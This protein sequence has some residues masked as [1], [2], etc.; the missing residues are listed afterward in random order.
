M[1]VWLNV[2]A[3][4]IS[5]TSVLSLIDVPLNLYI[6]TG[7]EGYG[8]GSIPPAVQVPFGMMRLSP[9][10]SYDNTAIVFHHYGGYH[11]GIVPCNEGSHQ[12]HLL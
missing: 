5:L 6:G 9:D 3:I 7:G 12:I 10:T 8:A 1:R 4:F 2:A 11:Y